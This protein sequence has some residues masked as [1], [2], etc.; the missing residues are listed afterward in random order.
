MEK[1]FVQIYTGNGKGKTTAALGAALRAVLSGMRVFV[2]QFMK[3]VEYA[4]LKVDRIPFEEISG[5]KI[6]IKQFGTKKMIG[7]GRV[8]GEKPDKRD[9]QR[10]SEG[11]KEIKEAISGREYDLVIADEL[12]VAVYFGL[13]KIKDAVSLI[14]EKPEEVELIITGRYAPHEFINIADLVTEMKEIKHYYQK[15]ITARK[16]IEF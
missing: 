4:E 1:G 15:G 13:I 9:Y 12:N 3:G 14:R 2:G 16:G 7:L 6:V 5:G 8:H 11:L 10:A